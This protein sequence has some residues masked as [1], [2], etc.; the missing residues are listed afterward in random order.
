VGRPQACLVDVYDTLLSLDF[1]KVRTGLPRLAGISEDSWRDRYRLMIPSLTLGQMSKAEVFTRIMLSSGVE[2]RPDLVR[3]L[4][5]MDREL[6]MAAARLYDDAIPFLETL[7]SRGIKIAIVSNCS[8]HTRDVLDGLGVTA[9]SD[10]LVLSCEVGAAK[11]AAE[12]FL[13]ALDR[14]RV[15]ADAAAFVDD[16][17]SYCAGAADLGLTAVRI[18]RGEIDGAVR[19]LMEVEAMLWG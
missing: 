2:P 16:Q 7:R 12:I 18:A 5:D 17:A 9:L 15:T 4:V 19:S 11:P 8:E 10:A 13:Y 1:T 3:E 14:L 6:L